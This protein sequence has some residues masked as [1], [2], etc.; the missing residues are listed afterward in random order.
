M[1]QRNQPSRR[2][3]NYDN[4]YSG[5]RQAEQF[6]DTS[7][8]QNYDADY[9]NDQQMGD[10]SGGRVYYEEVVIVPRRGNRNSQQRAYGNYDRDEQYGYGNRGRSQ[11]R[12][13]DGYDR[14]RYSRKG[15]SFGGS[16]DRAYG[17]DR[18]DYDR[19][20]DDGFARGTSGYR[21]ERDRY[22]SRDDRGFLDRA[23]DE[24]ASWFGDE[25][26]AR[27]REMDHR[28]HGP[29][30]YTRS[31]ERVLEDICDRLTD[32]ARVDARKVQVTVQGGEVTLD[33]SV[34]SRGHK[35]RAEDCAHDVSGV[36]HVQNNL[37]VKDVDDFGSNTETQ[38][39]TT[40]AS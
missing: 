23:G 4:D 9:D 26:A 40:D 6:E 7:Y 31:D 32:D 29:A 27:R 24:I 18:Y 36:N 1:A 3:S 10:G 35:R 13:D 34:R 12:D 22:R 11:Y 39:K 2:Q 20:D 28:G 8:R 25:D 33:G 16:R 38:T 5:S 19:S 14:D 21:N 15:R 17:N 37:R 30:N